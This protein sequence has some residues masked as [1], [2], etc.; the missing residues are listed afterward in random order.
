[1]II[2]L[3][4]VIIIAI[5]VVAMIG[6]EIPTVLAETDSNCSSGSYGDLCKESEYVIWDKN[7]PLVWDDFQGIPGTFDEDH[8]FSTLSIDATEAWTFYGID[9]KVWWEK[10]NNTPCEYKITKLDVVAVTSKIESWVRTSKTNDD[11]LKHEQG[12]F[13]IAQIHAQEFK[14]GYEGKDFACP[15]GIYDD[16]EIFNE[17][18][19]FWLQI[20]DDFHAMQKIYDTETEYHSDRKTQAEWDKKIK[21]LLSTE[22]YVK[23]TSIPKPTEEQ[24]IE[25]GGGCLIATATFGSELAPQVQ[26]LRE[27]R[28]NQLLNTESGTSFMNTFNEIYYSFSP[29]IAD[30]EREHPVFKEMIKL[31]ITPMIT[32]LSILNYVDMDSEVE[33]LGYGISLIL[34]NLG[35]YLG[36]P[37]ILIVGIRKIK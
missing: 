34:L 8:N 6:I 13:D 17:I 9:W 7:R 25:E 36:V 19:G 37:A 1:L 28:D 30:M 2:L 18:D 23:E 16:D 33:V 32:S 20:E 10:S 27:I 11:L 29:Y 24:T 26:Q 35:M 3:K 15:S 22:E 21:S 14:V 12:H 4:S 31:A 5:A